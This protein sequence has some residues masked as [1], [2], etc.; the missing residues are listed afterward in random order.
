MTT[1][2][3]GHFTSLRWEENHTSSSES[4]PR[5]ARATTS[6]RFSGG[7][8]AD[9]T[10]CE[11]ALVYVTQKTGRFTGAEVLAGRLD[12]RTG[13][14]AVE[15]HGSFTEDGTVHCS[16]EVVAGSGTGELAGLRGS[17][18]YTARH[19][20]PSVSYSFDYDLG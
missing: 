5:V 8:E 6:N 11:Y 19:G 10:T 15:Q 12:G 2:T 13:T 9:D 14:F 18:H 7:I 1:Q 16:F 3:T 4:V 17:G 20:E